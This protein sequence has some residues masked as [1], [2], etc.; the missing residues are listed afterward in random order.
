MAK[1]KDRGTFPAVL[2]SRR[3]GTLQLEESSIDDWVFRSYHPLQPVKIATKRVRLDPE[4]V[5]LV[6]WLPEKGG[7]DAELLTA[8]IEK[9]FEDL[10]NGFDRILDEA[11]PAIEAAIEEFWQIPDERGPTAKEFLDTAELNLLGLSAGSG[12]HE[13][14]LYDKGDLIGGHDLRL[15]LS[16]D[17]RPD[18]AS[19]DG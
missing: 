14:L 16:E 19:F 15:E 12:S 1:K 7:M 13:I 4:G 18:C 10:V 11:I 3:L 5:K 17:F 8:T 2:E 6:I 9:R